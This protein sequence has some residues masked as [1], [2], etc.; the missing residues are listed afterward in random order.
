MRYTT[1]RQTFDSEAFQS[2]VQM[3]ASL[4]AVIIV[5]RDQLT[6]GE[7]RSMVSRS[8]Q[9]AQ[10]PWPQ[11]DWRSTDQAPTPTTDKKLLRRISA[12]AL[13]DAP[14]GEAVLRHSRLYLLA[15]DTM[16]LSGRSLPNAHTRQS[17]REIYL[18]WKDPE[19]SKGEH[20]SLSWW[21]QSLIDRELKSYL[22]GRDQ[23]T[24]IVFGSDLQSFLQTVLDSEYLDRTGRILA[25]FEE[26]MLFLSPSIEEVQAFLDTIP[27]SSSLEPMRICLE[28]YLKGKTEVVYQPE[29]LDL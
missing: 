8:E 13:A 21:L 11:L 1:D 19:L 10:E 28:D 27:L 14:K 4:G 26:E 22:E 23:A 6:V 15:R 25:R 7:V 5:P 3:L 12:P 17:L 9:S 2:I 18:R 16:S 24:K 20:S 29:G